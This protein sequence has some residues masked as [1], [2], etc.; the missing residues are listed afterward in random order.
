[1]TAASAYRDSTMTPEAHVPVMLKETL[2]G[3][4]V[5][6]GGAYLDGTFGRGGHAR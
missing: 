1:M 2:D 3:L 5:R 6:E 4:R